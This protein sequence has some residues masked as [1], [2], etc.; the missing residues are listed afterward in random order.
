MDQ[1]DTIDFLRGDFGSNWLLPV[2]FGVMFGVISFKN[3]TVKNYKSDGLKGVT[4]KFV[5]GFLGGAAL[6]LPIVVFLFV[7]ER[8]PTAY[9]ISLRVE[10]D[11]VVLGQ[12]WPSSKILIPYTEIDSLEKIVERPNSRRRWRTRRIVIY[13]KGEAHQSFG[14]SN[15]T[16]EEQQVWERLVANVEASKKFEFPPREGE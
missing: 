3:Y 15:S 7:W 5:F 6:A 9:F 1:T 4:K 2:L 16:E 14:Y 13:S 8:W 11:G 12:R 10:K